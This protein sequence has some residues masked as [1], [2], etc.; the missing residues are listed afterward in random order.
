MNFKGFKDIDKPR[1]LVVEIFKNPKYLGE[2]QEGFVRK[3]LISG[4]EGQDGAISKMYYKS[5]KY[6]MELTET[7][8]ANRLPDTFEAFYHHKH[9]D[10]TMKCSFISIDENKTRYEYEVKYTRINWFMPKLMAIL[11]PGMYRKQGEKWM[12]NFKVFVEKQ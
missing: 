5:N 2:Y 8:T 9:M 6:D 11:F 10:N 3:E 1:S 12:Q 7:I 4:T